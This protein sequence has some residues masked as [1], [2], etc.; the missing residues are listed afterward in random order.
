MNQKPFGFRR[1][2]RLLN[3]SDFRT[4]FDQ[5]EVK[6]PSEQCTL[7]ARRNS[8]GLPRIGFILARKNIKRAVQRNR[9]KRFCRE[10]LRLNQH[11]L[12]DLD[13]ILMG[14]KGL[15]QLSD[16]Q[17]HKLLQKLFEKLKKRASRS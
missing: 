6:A 4:V 17:L 11:Q 10:Y 15:D 13:I 8:L 14:R 1:N 2:L 12:P 3:A 7:L 9:I 5:V 16:E